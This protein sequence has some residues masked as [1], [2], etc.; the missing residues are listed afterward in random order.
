MKLLLILALSLPAQAGAPTQLKESDGCGDLEC[1]Q[2]GIEWSVLEDTKATANPGGGKVVGH[3]KKGNEVMTAKG[4]F[5]IS[6]RGV[7]KLTADKAGGK[8]GQELYY[9]D[10]NNGRGLRLYTKT[11]KKVESPS[12]YDFLSPQM[13]KPACKEKCSGE[14]LKP[15][16][17]NTYIEVE[18]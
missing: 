18:L 14:V 9:F 1:C 6:S 3:L 2:L 8:A 16:S 12:G 17:G 13:L 11:G 10:P 15:S 4:A 7:L 5:T